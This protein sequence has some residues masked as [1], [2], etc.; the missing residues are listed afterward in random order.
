MQHSVSTYKL[1]RGYLNH[2]PKKSRQTLG[3]KIDTTF[4]SIIEWTSIAIWQTKGLKIP[5]LQKA[6]AQTDL[7][8]CFLQVAWEVED[9]DKKKYI[10]ISE[11]VAEVGRM[12]G[13]WLKRMQEEQKL[14]PP[15]KAAEE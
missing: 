1:W 12:L 8:K 4:I 5:T 9:L 3:T 11:S 6:I 15:S 10:T 2:F 13:A 7:L 14:Q